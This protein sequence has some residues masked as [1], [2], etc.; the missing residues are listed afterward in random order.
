LDRAARV[1]DVLLTEHVH[2][3]N[4]RVGCRGESGYESAKL[5]LCERNH[6][7]LCYPVRIPHHYT[8]TTMVLSNLRSLREYKTHREN[9]W[10]ITPHNTA[11][12]TS[13][14]PCKSRGVGADTT[15]CITHPRSE[16]PR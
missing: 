10:S 13:L 2:A 11:S 12:T 3:V 5:S 9:C 8:L 7:V 16:G 4:D 1:G 14:G 6:L 15:V